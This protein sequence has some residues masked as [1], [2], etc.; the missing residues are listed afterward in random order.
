MIIIVSSGGW[1][2]VTGVVR[3]VR[4]V[5]CLNGADGGHRTNASTVEGGALPLSYVRVKSK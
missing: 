5:K 2:R 3:S 1:N 4:K